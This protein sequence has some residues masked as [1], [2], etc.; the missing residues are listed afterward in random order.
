MHKIDAFNEWLME[1]IV[2]AVSTPWAFYVCNLSILATLLIKRPEDAYA[3]ALF[4]S[5][6]W[7][8]AVMLPVLA[9]TD[10]VQTT[11]QMAMLT[12]EVTLLRAEFQKITQIC[13]RLGVE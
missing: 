12:E 10:K 13:D 11:R 5:S 7:F 2:D 4:I 3:W 6:I 9:A 1:R 8:Q